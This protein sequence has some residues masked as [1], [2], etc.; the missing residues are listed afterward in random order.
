MTAHWE[1]EDWSLAIT[2]HWL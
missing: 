2:W 1:T